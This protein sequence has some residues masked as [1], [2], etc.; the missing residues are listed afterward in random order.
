MTRR[1]PR[2]SP[3]VF[4]DPT[5]LDLLLKATL[6]ACVS[7]DQA[8]ARLYGPVYSQGTPMP[9][10]I[11][12]S[13]KAGRAAFALYW[14]K[15]NKRNTHYIMADKASDSKAS[16][17]AVLGAARDCPGDRN[18]VIYTSSEYCIRS[19]CFWAGDSETCGW[20]CANGEELRIAVDW[21][22]KRRTPT[23]FRYVPSNGSNA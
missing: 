2:P 7:S 15:D 12:T 13:A 19:F 10:Y 17:L 14:G 22:A 18:L 8:T 6:E 4:D 5:P 16:I 1:V 21:L 9:V 3:I 11:G 23:E 20:S